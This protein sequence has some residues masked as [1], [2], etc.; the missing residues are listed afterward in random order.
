MSGWIGRD[1]CVVF[2]NAIIGFIQETKAE[3]AVEA[4]SKMVV[5]EA[6]VRREG[7]RQRVPSAQLVP[8]DVVLLQSGD[9]VPADLR[10]IQ[11][12]PAGG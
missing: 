3:K 10:L 4:L 5:T 7:R 12:K 8:G 6:T 11:V 2:I 1:F 9:R